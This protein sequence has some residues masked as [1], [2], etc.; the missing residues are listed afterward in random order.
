MRCDAMVGMRAEEEEEWEEWEKDKGKE[1]GGR[2]GRS[3]R[4]VAHVHT[5][6]AR[7][8]CGRVS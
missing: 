1:E 4:E 2:R 6:R 8:N 5:P 3:R 7:A